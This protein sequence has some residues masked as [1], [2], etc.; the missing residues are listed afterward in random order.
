MVDDLKPMEAHTMAMSTNDGGAGWKDIT[1]E[2]IETLKSRIAD[3]DRIIDAYEHRD[4][5]RP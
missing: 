1:G 5:Q 4:A 3:L 2:R